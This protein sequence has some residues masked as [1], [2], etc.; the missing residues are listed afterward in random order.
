[1]PGSGSAAA[2]P[3]TASTSRAACSRGTSLSRR[4]AGIDT[5]AFAVLDRVLCSFGH[6]PKPDPK[7]RSD[8]ATFA[9]PMTAG[10]AAKPVAAFGEIPGHTADVLSAM[11]RDGKL[12]YA[13]AVGRRAASGSSSPPSIP[14]RNA[15]TRCWRFP[16]CA[17]GL[18]MSPENPFTWG[19]N[20]G[21][22][23]APISTIRT[24]ANRP[25]EL[26]RKGN[27]AAGMPGTPADPRSFAGR[28]RG[29]SGLWDSAWYGFLARFDRDG[30]SAPGKIATLDMRIPYVTQ[31]V[32]VCGSMELLPPRGVSETLDPLRLTQ[33]SPEQ[34]HLAVWDDE[35]GSSRL[36]AATA[37][38]PS[39]ATSP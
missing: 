27:L 32:D 29:R 6:L 30:R 16:A 28:F 20:S 7:T 1:M 14:V 38:C 19:G 35:A 37:R 17:S 31:V 34:A 22:T 13:Y 15:A 26:G 4:A 9:V 8:T 33:T 2:M 18:A 11:P 39:L 36:N 23:L 10:G 3:S 24:L 25:S 5:S 21:T 12:V